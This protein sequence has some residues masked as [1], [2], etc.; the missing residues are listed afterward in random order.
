V[1]WQTFWIEPS[2][3]VALG[4]RRYHAEPGHAGWDCAQGWHQAVTWTG[5]G[6]ARF[7][8]HR[9]GRAVLAAPEPVAAGDP[10]W[11]AACQDGCGYEFTD[12]DH[13]QRWQELI[14]VRPADGQRFVLHSALVPPGIPA[15]GPGAGFD[16]WWFPAAWR[17]ADGIAY[18][19]RCP[20]PDGSPGVFLD[21]P[22]DA[23]ATG[24][25]T[26]ARTGDPCAS[27][28]TAS[29]SIAIGDPAKAGYYHGFLQ[30]GVLTDHLG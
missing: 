12:A 5:E 20:R 18:T 14:W 1:T 26:W 8:P 19:V 15:A 11:P 29:P 7:E 17:G 30:A 24:G 22:V 25:G 27:N 4:L 9:D 23:P 10:R 3:Q 28:V 13:R 21:W 16:S 6:P 2:K